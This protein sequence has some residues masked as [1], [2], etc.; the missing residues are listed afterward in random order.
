MNKLEFAIRMEN[1]GRQYYL[2]QALKNQD[3]ALSKV[4]NILADS[5]KEHEELLKKRLNNE[6][7][8]LGGDS[9]K[10]IKSVFNGL[11]DFE[12][13]TMKQPLDVYRL[14]VEIERRVLIFIRI[15]LRPLITIRTRS[16]SNSYL[17]KKE[18]I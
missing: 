5:E 6:E 1:E 15:C 16:C 8:S 17:E 3:N 7:Y 13:S 9:I 10:N 12:A 18:S 11:K 2:E 4:F 14:A